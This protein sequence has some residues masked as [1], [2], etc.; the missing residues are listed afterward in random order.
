[1]GFG[2]ACFGLL[3]EQMLV[4]YGIVVGSSLHMGCKRGSNAMGTLYNGYGLLA[5]RDLTAT[6][7]NKHRC[8]HNLVSST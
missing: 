5:N 8:G 7:I 1:M 3:G 4:Q 2:W 6:Q